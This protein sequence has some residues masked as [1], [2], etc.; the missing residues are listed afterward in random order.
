M[1][2]VPVPPTCSPGRVVE[3]GSGGRGPARRGSCEPR[4]SLTQ[5]RGALLTASLWDGLVLSRPCRTSGASGK[6]GRLEQLWCSRTAAQNWRPA[7]WTARLC[8]ARPGDLWLA[9]CG[10]PFPGLNSQPQFCEPGTS[11]HL[12]LSPENLAVLGAEGCVWK[13]SR[14]GLPQPSLPVS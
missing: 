1:F 14:L 5:V 9:L 7:G 12:I 13:R 2:A 3:V 6:P 8:T 11:L 10:L 4:N